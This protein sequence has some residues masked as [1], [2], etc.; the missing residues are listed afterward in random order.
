MGLRGSAV[1]KI[2]NQSEL[3][4]YH[5]KANFEYLIQEFIPFKE[6]VGIFYVRFP[7]QEKGKVTGIV[8]KELFKVIGDGI[9]TIEKLI[10]QNPRFE[11]QLKAIYK[12]LGEN[13]YEVLP[14]NQSKI[15]VP[16]GNHCRGAK[17]L[18]YSHFIS[19]ELDEVLNEIALQIPGFYFGRLDVMYNSWEELLQ[20]KNFLLVEVNGAASEPTHIYDPKHSIFFAWKELARHI[21]YM[22]KISEINHKKG[23]PYLTFKEGIHQYKMHNKLVNTYENI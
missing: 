14:L 23:I 12:E 10:K 3:L 22:F 7:N 15:L 18:D 5:K 20:G 11:F 6:E 19:S 13:I 1:K 2:K 8:Y 16:L 21:T 17:F 4:I 9:S